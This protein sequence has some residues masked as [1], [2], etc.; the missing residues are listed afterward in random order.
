MIGRT[1]CE[2]VRWCSRI[3]LRSHRDP[4]TL[5]KCLPYITIRM[6]R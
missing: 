3:A 6:P 5:R 1:R 2:P 4:L